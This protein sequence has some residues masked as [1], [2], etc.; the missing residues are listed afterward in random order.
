LSYRNKEFGIII[1]LD[2][3]GSRQRIEDNI[4]SFLADWDSVLNRLEKNVHILE[5]E[6]SSLYRTGIKTKDIFDNIQI[7]YPTDDPR[8]SYIDLTGSNSIWWSIQHSADLL[9]NLIR[10]GITKRIPLRGCISMGYIQEFRNG[11][12]SKSMIENAKLAESF[13]MIGVIAGPSSIR[14]LNNKSYWSSTRFY[15][16]VKNNIR[17]KKSNPTSANL[18]NN[19]ALLNLIRGK[20]KIYENIDDNEIES[21]IQEQIRVYGNDET[22]RTKWQNTK[23]FF[24]TVPKISDENLFL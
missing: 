22:I 11:Y 17:T 18:F 19:L 21:V 23:S 20:S 13:D 24:E 8:T 16:F 2:V 6:L 10:F 3:L 15:Y 9:I 4:D 12:Y 5:G 7:F 14:V 1:L